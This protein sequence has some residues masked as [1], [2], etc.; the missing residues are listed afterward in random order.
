MLSCRVLEKCLIRQKRTFGV[1][2]ATAATAAAVRVWSHARTFC[3]TWR[4][5]RPALREATDAH[6]VD[7]RTDAVSQAS[8]E[9]LHYMVTENVK[10][11]GV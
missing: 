3:S 9:M 8:P 7:L 2:D 5:V 1:R 4:S 11:E 10:V 6:V